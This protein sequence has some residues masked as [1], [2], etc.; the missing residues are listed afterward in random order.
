MYSPEESRASSHARLS[1]SQAASLSPPVAA[2]DSV[3]KNSSS[4]STFLKHFAPISLR[5]AISA[6]LPSHRATFSKRPSETS[7]VPEP[8]V[9]PLPSPAASA[10]RFAIAENS[11]M[12]S[13]DAFLFQNVIQAVE[14]DIQPALDA[15]AEIYSRSKMSL[16]DEYS[17][18][19]PPQGE[20]I[21]GITIGG[22]GGAGA[23]GTRHPYRFGN[24]AQ[25]GVLPVLH[26]ASSSSEKLAVQGKLKQKTTVGRSENIAKTPEP[27]CAQTSLS[28]STL[29]NEFANMPDA[30]T[31]KIRHCSS[32]SLMA[33]KG[34]HLAA[35]TSSSATTVSKI[36]NDASAAN[37]HFIIVS[38]DKAKEDRRMSQPSIGSWITWNFPS[39]N[40]VSHSPPHTNRLTAETKLKDI[41]RSTVT[42]VKNT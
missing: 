39:N 19:L 40:S 1:S 21:Y 16:A 5:G 8:F 35:K 12:P 22:G 10:T 14:P 18:H 31:Q 30:D 15:I 32:I 29:D 42:D 28:I 25:D 37:G 24:A 20:I 38:T 13:I 9:T 34:A 36:D 11:R 4:I 41:L 27:Y 6:P 3:T 23:G 17:A 7:Q 33:R 2:I 26:E